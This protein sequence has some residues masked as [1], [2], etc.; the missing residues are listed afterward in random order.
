MTVLEV[1]AVEQE[2]V[3]FTAVTPV[4]GVDP[5]WKVVVFRDGATLA[6]FTV[7]NVAAMTSGE[8]FTFPTGLVTAQ[9]DKLA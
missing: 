3:A 7:A 6:H 8:D 5:P 9:A 4:D 1:M 2:A